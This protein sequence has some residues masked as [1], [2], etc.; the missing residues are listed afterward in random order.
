[1]ADR[2]PDALTVVVPTWN[3]SGLL[4]RC[5]ASLL[6]QTVPCGIVV[7]DDASSDDTAEVLG[8]EFPMVAVIRY[9]VN[10]GFAAAAN[11][12]LQSCKT[13]FAALL[14]NDTEA[15][16]RWVEEGLKVLR[17]CPQ[18]GF[19]ASKLIDFW[20]RGLLDA[21]GD[22]YTRTG[23]PLKRGH[24]LPAAR[25]SVDEPVL[26][27]SAGAAFYRMR[28]FDAIGWLDEDYFMYLEDVDLCLRA[29]LSGFH[30]V[31]ASKAVV[32]HMEAASDPLARGL[33]P[34]A[35]TAPQAPAQ[36]LS[37]RRVYWITRNRWRLMWTYQPLRHAPWLL[38]GW[39]KSAGYHLL[40]GGSFG[41]FARGSLAGVAAAPQALAKRRR[42]LE[43][44]KSEKKRLWRML[45][46]F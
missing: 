40:K 18:C 11:R 12:G 22:R 41:A 9:E 33:T 28:L 3:A 35:D 6:R 42:V 15:D 37:P 44:G 27:A 29:Q 46:E 14:N 4:R 31:F 13:E 5:L 23:L 8:K 30:G 16:P 36:S 2:T 7:V 17:R 24:G 43:A 34:V 39:V 20:N 21:A 25:F 32:Y 1:M 10:R 38:F 45:A 26:A 19:A